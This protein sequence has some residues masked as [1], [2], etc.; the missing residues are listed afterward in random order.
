YHVTRVQNYA[1]P[2]SHK[3]HQ[4]I[5]GIEEKFTEWK[6]DDQGNKKRVFKLPIPNFRQLA[7]EHIESVLVSHKAKNKVVT[8]NKNI[9]KS[10]KEIGRASCRQRG[11]DE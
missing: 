5:K 7:K 1:I 6:Y 8:R 11:Q 3:E 10:K 4:N 2:I 9:T